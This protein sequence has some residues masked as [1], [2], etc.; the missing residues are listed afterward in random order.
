MAL[1][2]RGKK[3][4]FLICTLL[5]IVLILYVVFLR[6]ATTSDAFNDV[7]SKD[8]AQLARN[9]ILHYAGS[10][11]A[12]L[13]LN[14]T[15]VNRT[16]SKEPAPQTQNASEA[17]P[18]T[19]PFMDEGKGW[20]DGFCNEFLSNRFKVLMTPCD[21]ESSRVLCYGSPYD[22]KMGTCI[23][24][25][26]AIDT[27]K[28]YKIMSDD[29][30]AVQTS[31]SMWLLRED[32]PNV[33][34]CPQPDFA[35]MEP[36]MMGGDYVKRLAKTSI[37]TVP[38]GECKKMIPGTT[39]LFMGFH[40]HIYFKY[41]SWYSLHNGILNY[42]EETGRRPTKIIRIPQ[43]KSEFLFPEYEKKL[44]PEANVTSFEELSSSNEGI[45]CFE[46]V[47]ITPWAYSTNAFRCK[48]ADAIS[49][50]RN[51]CYKCNSRGLPGTRFA[52]FRR[53][54]LSACG[55]TED[56]QDKDRPKSI[57]VQIRKAYN[58]FP[59]DEAH[60][61]QRVLEN[62]REL[63]DGLKKAFPSVAVHTMYA[64]D[65]S[66]CEQ[67]KMVYNCDLFTGIHG[68]GLVHLWWLRD[69]AKILELVPRSQLANPTFKMLSALTGRQYHEYTRVRGS[70]YFVSVD[71]GDVI[72]EVK[73]LNIF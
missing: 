46:Q 48:M 45:M 8:S 5:L 50:L 51:R 30:D 53:R 16:S 22:D 43:R 72:N 32:T 36:L 61:F 31:S 1:R 60:T 10:N 34:P 21:K 57:V 58:R 52:T 59:G 40:D 73:K 2:L 9:L 67:I 3:C 24:K 44:F 13:G 18:V 17:R 14:I 6:N 47:I 69:D 62:G 66:I 49:R 55:I 12:K 26:L 19:F 54:S 56:A 42:E 23:I 28:F 35:P 15:G 41:L 70:Q 29:R 4:S 27:K 38:Q 33:N 37:L 25:K 39:F 7:G 11:P 63:V 71:V 68:A 64:E 20:S 65:L